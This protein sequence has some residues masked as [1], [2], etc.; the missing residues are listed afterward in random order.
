M[1]DLAIRC[2]QVSKTYASESGNVFALDAISLQVERGKLVALLG[3]S[4]CGKSTL[5]SVLAG[6]VSPS[7]GKVFVDGEEPR[8]RGDVGMMFQ[9]ALLFPWR[10]VLKNVLLPAE[11]LRL[12]MDG[13][14]AR[15]RELLALMGLEDWESRHA[16]ELSGG[17]RQRVALARVLLPDP[18]ILLLDE[19]FGALDEMTRESL[20]LEMMR[21][22]NRTSKTL[23]LVTHNVYEAV[24]LA[25]E[26]F[27]MTSRPGRLA[28]AVEV[29][30]PQPRG[31]EASETP[32]FSEKVAEARR[33]LSEGGS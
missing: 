3:P 6:L 25:D 12:P 29:P 17:M 11:L 30:L 13:A 28:G 32:V 9:D 4:G 18:D 20:D 2:E 1:V 27:V 15:A 24:L 22:A 23:V 10:S 8:P 31:I 7:A 21:I 16:W 26:I 33:L 19:P 14:T 5:L